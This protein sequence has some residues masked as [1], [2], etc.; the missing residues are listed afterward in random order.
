M[1]DETTRP[2]TPPEETP[3]EK[4]PEPAEGA[5]S[6]ERPAKHSFREGVA[7]A[8]GYT[9]EVASILGQQGGD[10]VKAEREVAQADAE[11][12]IDRIDGEG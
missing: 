10:A 2:E 3:S 4:P 5:A 12:L 1:T 9:V 8:V 6:T 11:D 7:K